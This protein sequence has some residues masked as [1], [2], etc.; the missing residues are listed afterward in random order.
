[1][2]KFSLQT[3]L[4]SAFGVVTV[5]TI[6]I[7]AL[8]FFATKRVGDYVHGIGKESLPAVQS[9]L[10]AKS[11]LESIRVAQRTLLSPN[12][13]GEDRT[14]QYQNIE[15][16]RLNYRTGLE[17][18]AAVAV[19]PADV[20]ELAT[21]RQQLDEWRQLNDHF[22]ATVR[23]LEAAD[24]TNPLELETRQEAFRNDHNT[25]LLR[26]AAHVLEHKTFTG[27]TDP[28]ACRF[29]RWLKEH[30]T[31]NPVISAAMARA[32]E[33]HARFHA[34]MGTLQAELA[35]GKNE[36]AQAT[37]LTQLTPAAESTMALFT[38]ILAETAKARDTYNTL[39]QIAMVAVRDKQRVAFGSLQELVDRQQRDAEAQVAAAEVDTRSTGRRLIVASGV[40]ALLAAGLGLGLALS[41]SRRIRQ[42]STTLDSGAEQTAAAAGE[43]AT[44]STALATGA[45]QQAASLEETSATLTEISSMTKRTVDQANGAKTTSRDARV[46]AEASE[47]EV[48][49]MDT[50]MA[51]ISSAMKEVEAIVKTIDEIAFQTNLLSLNASV[52][53]ARAGESGAGFA[54]V[55]GEVRVL[56]QRAADAAKDTA[57]RIET[58]GVASKSAQTVVVAVRARL[59]EILA[60]TREVDSA[61]EAI[62]A[63]AQEQNS[64]L[65]QISTAVAEMD[66]ITQTNAATSEESSAAS[67]ELHA[68]T[69]ELRAAMHDLRSIVDGGTS[70]E[71][72]PS[73]ESQPVVRPVLAKGKKSAAAAAKPTFVG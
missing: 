54:V 19:D 2:K 21:L 9:L 35:E 5:V 27:G 10:V 65:S 12:L 73:V 48:A 20:A 36:A 46:A 23:S 13:V 55:A 14:R 26:A 18:Y 4:L 68:Q 50:A 38:D 62:A 58:A 53:A 33:P 63:A 3:R 49:R 72:P 15:A 71:L 29:G 34:A 17:G 67:E 60:R 32:V 56:A 69:M 43:I 37:Y 47:A 30:R 24:I 16:A 41:T 22:I 7:A 8:G 40:G 25:A 66:R 52:E 11:S 42:I 64:G 57:S 61:M 70:R 45:S 6:G 39:N 59:N 28:T 31:T 44:A 51:A 1:M